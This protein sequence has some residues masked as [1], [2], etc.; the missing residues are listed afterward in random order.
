MYR[1]REF[2]KAQGKA[3]YEREQAIQAAS[4]AWERFELTTQY[5]LEFL[6]EQPPGDVLESLTMDEWADISQQIVLVNPAPATV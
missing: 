2:T 1:V 6:K 4:D 3:A 5:L